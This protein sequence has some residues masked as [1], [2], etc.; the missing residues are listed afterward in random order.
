MHQPIETLDIRPGATLLVSGPEIAAYGFGHGHPFGPD[1]HEA[2]MR[3]ARAAGLLE[4]VAHLQPRQATR[5]E[6]TLFHTSAYVDLVER[7]SREGTGYLDGGD[8]PA[9]PGIFEAAS[10]VVGATLRAVE[11]VM[12]TGGRAFVPIAGLHHASR[13][14]AAGFCVFNDCAIAAEVLRQRYGLE[15]V[16]YIDID[17]HHGDGVFYG[18]EDDPDMLFADTHEDGRYLYP[19]T[20]ARTESGRGRAAGTKL[21]LPLPPGAGDAEFFSAWEEIEAYLD[22]ARPEFILLQ[23]G[24]DS[25]AGDPITHLRFSE[26][27]H[28]H[29]A[30][31]LCR[32]AERHAQGRVVAMGGGGY[33]RDNLGRAWTAVLAAFAAH[34]EASG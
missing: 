24:A 29:A 14:S 19:G 2:F 28:A 21:N 27:A 3:A 15:R 18:F 23:C 10:W 5:E 25:L 4:R 26:A 22:A 34:G 1:R 12:V 20:G 16:A 33:N 17:A 31:R 32:L 9:V 11:Q 8:T 6:L 7:R 13:S 30:E